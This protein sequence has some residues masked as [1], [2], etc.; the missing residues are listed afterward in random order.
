MQEYQ[1]NMIQTFESLIYNALYF[2]SAIFKL[3][4]VAI[5]KSLIREIVYLVIC[6]CMLTM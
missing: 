2:V 5:F 6:I 3:H 1:E 4:L